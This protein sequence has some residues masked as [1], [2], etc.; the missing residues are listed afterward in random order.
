MSH[1]CVRKPSKDR[2]PNYAMRLCTYSVLR[3]HF[4]KEQR[5]VVYAF[6]PP[7][8][9]PE[10]WCCPE[11]L[12]MPP[13]WKC[14]RPGWMELWATWSSA[15]CPWSRHGGWKQVIFKVPSNPYHSVI[16]WFDDLQCSEKSRSSPGGCLLN[17]RTTCTFERR[18]KIC[19]Y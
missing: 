10:I 1:Y 11:K 6:L 13:P 5:V 9:Y 16:L 14:S 8:K 2:I 3:R 17:K 4:G 15:R 12:W 18:G 19:E 7:R